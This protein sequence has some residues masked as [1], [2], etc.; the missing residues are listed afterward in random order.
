LRR[1]AESDFGEDVEELGDQRGLLVL[2]VHDLRREEV[3]FIG[4]ESAKSIAGVCKCISEPL[5]VG[6]RSRCGLD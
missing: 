2:E 5:L 1:E 6:E 3:D 4:K